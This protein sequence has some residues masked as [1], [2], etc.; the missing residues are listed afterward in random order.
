MRTGLRL[1]RQY[2]GCDF[3]TDPASVLKSGVIMSCEDGRAA[4]VWPGIRPLSSALFYAPRMKSNIFDA[5][6]FRPRSLAA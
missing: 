6:P 1:T 2:I 4:A 3:E 5:G